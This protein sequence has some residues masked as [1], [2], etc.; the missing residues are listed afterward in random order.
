MHE[1]ATFEPREFKGTFVA[2]DGATLE[3]REFKGA[4]VVRVSFT[5]GPGMNI[6]SPSSLEAHEPSADGIVTSQL[7]SYGSASA[8]SFR[9][10]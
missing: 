10:Q 4:L 5:K 6:T 7:G 1:G 9:F 2:R 3:P 8:R